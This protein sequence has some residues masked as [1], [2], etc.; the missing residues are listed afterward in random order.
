MEHTQKNERELKEQAKRPLP[1]KKKRWM[2]WVVW[3]LLM[4]PILYVAIQLL[5]IFSPNVRTQIAALDEMTDSITVQGVAVMQSTNVQDAGGVLHYTISAGERVPVNGQVAALFGDT[6]AAQAQL[7]LESIDAE[8]EQLTSAQKTLTEGGDVDMLLKQRQKGIYDL[9]R[10]IEAQ[11]YSHLDTPKAEITTAANKL[12]VA[13]GEVIDFTPRIEALTAQREQYVAAAVPTGAIVAPATGYFVPSDRYDRLM[14]SYEAADTAS[15]LQLQEM[16]SQPVQYYSS[17][18]VGHIITDYAWNFFTIVSAEQAER[19]KEGKKLHLNFPDVSEEI[20]PVE[21][22]GVL[23]DEENQ[24]AKVQLKCEN[25][26]ENVLKLRTETAKII[27][28]TQKGIRIDKQALRIIEGQDAVYILKPGNVVALRKIDI[29][30]EDEYYML[31]P[32]KVEKDVNEIQLYD[33]VIVDS[34]GIELYDE[35]IIRRN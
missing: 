5:I 4:I 28:D 24:I 23:V 26:N 1:R 13:T 11:N 30:L 34:G 15:P 17:D 7:T 16:L 25:I 32:A 10:Q 33:E 14:T 18:I 12:Q 31:L 29:L 9:L 21:V 6:A 35:R 19:F 20:L 27:F 22:M 3:C 8:I 2:R